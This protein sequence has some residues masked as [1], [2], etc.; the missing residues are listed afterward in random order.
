MSFNTVIDTSIDARFGD[1]LDSTAKL[2]LMLEVANRAK[3]N[4]DRIETETKNE[5]KRIGDLAVEAQR[6][7]EQLGGFE[8]GQIETMFE[9]F[10]RVSGV[11]QILGQMGVAIDGT[12][13]SLPSVLNQLIQRGQ[14]AKEEIEYDANGFPASSKLTLQD[15]Y[16]V[17][18]AYTIEDVINSDTGL[19]N[20]DK[21]IK[22]VGAVRGIPV[23]EEVTYRPIKQTT[24]LFGQPYEMTVRHDLI[25]KT[26]IMYSLTSF[27]T[28]ATVIA[29]AVPDLNGDGVIGNPVAADP[30]A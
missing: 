22:G 12:T 13:Y 6:L 19:P 14:V 28:E 9:D 17:M 15:G 7:A 3:Q 8:K 25:V 4:D 24:A 23:T 5:L 26:R 11:D 20:G 29:S 21:K 16:I 27:L 1:A 2:A 18:M 10:L 30:L